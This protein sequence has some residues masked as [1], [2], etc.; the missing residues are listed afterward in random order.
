MENAT[1]GKGKAARKLVFH[2]VAENLYRLEQSGRYYA[3]LKRGDKQFRRSLKTRDRK[4]AERRLA[5]LRAKVGNLKINEEGRLSFEEVAAR[6]MAATAHTIKPSTARRR[7][8]CIKNLTPFFAGVLI[9]NIQTQHCER[10]LTERASKIA[11]QTM[12]NELNA[13]RPIFAYAVKAGLLLSNPASDIRRKKGVQ[14]PMV[15]PTREQFR[16]L[17]QA[18]RVSDGRPDSQAKAKPGADLVELLAYSGCRIAE[19]AALTWADVDF[20]ANT[21]RI[22][23]GIDGTKNYEVRTIPMTEALRALLARL[24]ADRQPSASDRV[25]LT[26]R[27]HTCLRTA[28]R[29]LGYPLFSHHDFRHFFATT[30]IESG[31][32]I[33]TVSR[34]LGHKDGGASRNA[35]LRPPPPRT[36]L[37]DGQTGDVLSPAVPKH[38]VTR[39]GYNF[40][41]RKIAGWRISHT[42]LFIPLWDRARASEL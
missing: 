19:A 35:R 18:I 7:Q 40:P 2:L 6:W 20:D 33:P 13:L 14:K 11:P 9:R 28:C 21:L 23:G 4:L 22:R 26:D 3:L 30:C 37:L 25:S 16:K 15:I 39:M 41:A 24:H 10:W 5:D 8:T 34:W 31:V 27:A 1:Q 12:A 29:R 38:R 17:V 42:T 36:Q 32:D